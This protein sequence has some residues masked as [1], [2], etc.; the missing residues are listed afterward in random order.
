MALANDATIDAM[1]RENDLTATIY[2]ISGTCPALEQDCRISELHHSRIDL[3]NPGDDLAW[4][5]P[6]P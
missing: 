1:L 6:T 2:S 3:P 4:L 5:P